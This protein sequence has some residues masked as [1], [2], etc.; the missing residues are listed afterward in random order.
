LPKKSF[1]SNPAFLSLLGI[2]L[3]ILWEYLQQKDSLNQVI[4]LY[5]VQSS[6]IGIFTFI[7]MMV[8]KPKE[9]SGKGF[10]NTSIG[11]PEKTG[12]M[13]GF[14][15]VHYGFFHLVYFVVISIKL[16]GNISSPTL[17]QTMLGLLIVQLIH[18]YQN[19]KYV[20]AGGQINTSS[21]FMLPYLRI[22]PMHLFILA[23]VFLGISAGWI[24]IILKIIADL[25]T[26]LLYNRLVYNKP[27]D[28]QGPYQL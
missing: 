5:W 22:I 2:N 27:P 15:A 10:I 21:L 11:L 6:L 8:L 25:L 1:Y 28:E 18:F 17:L 3:I 19:R 16:K 13:G 24:F 14:F 12:C 23:P 20:Q 9:Q 26:Y 7:E 4:F